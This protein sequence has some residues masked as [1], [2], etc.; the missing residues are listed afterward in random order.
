MRILQIL[1]RKL[2]SSQIRS[3]APSSTF[4]S[5]QFHSLSN[6]ASFGIAFDIDGVLLR[7]NIPIGSSPQALKSLYDDSGTLKVPYVFLTN[8]GGVPESKRAKELARLLDVNILPLQ[9]IQ[10]HTPFKQLMKRFEDELVVAVGKG[11][12]AEV[13][14]EYGFKNVLSIDEYASYFDNIDPLAQYKKWTDKQDVNQNS[15]SKHVAFSNDPC[16]QRAQAVFVVS[17]S[18]DWSR[19]IQ[20][21]CD[22]LRTGGLPGKEIAHQPPLFFANDDLAYQAL[23]PSERLGMGAFR[24]ALE[25]VFNAIHPAALKYTS[26]GKPNPFVFKNAE[27]VLMQVLQSSHYNNQVDGREQF[28]KTLYMIGDNPAVDIK[29]ARQAGN[30]WFSILT[31]TG[32]FKGKENY[33]ECPADLVVDTVEE[34]VD[35]ILSKECIS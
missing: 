25:S 24:I 15:K 1:T 8:G 12:P 18:V 13:M 32:V 28:F 14:S 33:D 6:P 5:R 30:P 20:V 4:S 29:G 19:D 16:S 17:D 34:A 31:R 2:S 3:T 7:G 27:T 9:V 10:G 23:F 22:I 26:Y 21:L 11:E 35:Y